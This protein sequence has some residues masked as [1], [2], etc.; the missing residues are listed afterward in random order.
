M[1][2][3]K[4][5]VNGKNSNKLSRREFIRSA[6]L[7]A[8][9]AAA[10]PSTFG[11]FFI[12]S[13]R[14]TAQP[15][16]LDQ[17]RVVVSRDESAHTGSQI[18]T[19]YVKVVMDEAIRRLTGIFETG[20]A[21]KSSFPG[22]TL[23]SVIGIKINSINTPLSTHP[24]VVDALTLGLQEM[25]FNG[26]PFP[27]NNII[28][29]DRYNW[30]LQAAGYTI[31]ASPTGVRCFGTD[32]VGY[33]STVSLNC[34]GS[35]QHP[36]RI[37]TEYID[38]HV[39]FAVLKNAGGAGLTLTL[40]NN[41]GCIDSPSNLHSNNCNPGIPSVNQQIRDELNV[42]EALFIVDAIFGCYSGGPMGPPNMIYDG[43]IMGQDRVAVDSIGRSI[44]EEYGCTTLAYST[45]VDTAA[46][47]PYNLGTNNLDE[48]HR[49]DVLNPSLPVENLRLQKENRNISLRW[50]TP[51]YTGYFS[52][53]RSS[54][55]SFASYE[56]IGLTRANRFIDHE[57]VHQGEKSFY[58]VVKTW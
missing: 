51:E 20:E 28:I 31:N 26:T 9:A 14:A 43:I 46:E 57:A 7:A 34:S 18:N 30:E 48:I 1:Q 53:Q 12:I 25:T 58:R 52:V 32:T 56:E 41:Y 39:D 2:K 47:P 22:I 49:L 21:Y 50:S 16:P 45:H 8:T 17:V 33:D 44:L 55:P 11:S 19:D 4:K 35:I 3:P 13:R 24:A 6:S 36:S 29:W 37:L 54:D 42:I 23:D 5:N 27:A 15:P 10:L 38:Y 40:K